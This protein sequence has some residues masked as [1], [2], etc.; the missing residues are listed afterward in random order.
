MKINADKCKV[1]VNG[2]AVVEDMTTGDFSMRKRGRT[3][4]MHYRNCSESGFKLWVECV[5]RTTPPQ[6]SY[7][8]LTIDLITRVVQLHHAISGLIGTCSVCVLACVHVYV[9]A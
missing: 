2:T 3:V 7:L 5:E 8:K 4:E 1:D 6:T 9:C